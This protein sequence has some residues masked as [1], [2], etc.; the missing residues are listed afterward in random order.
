MNMA[1]VAVNQRAFGLMGVLCVGGIAAFLLLPALVGEMDANA[2]ALVKL[3]DDW[4]AAA[5]ARDIE[6]VASFYAEDAMAYPPN[7]PVAMGR[8]AAKK[9]WAELLADPSLAISWKATNAEVS[10]SGELA[11]TSGTYELSVK[12]P[13]GKPVVEKGKY[14]CVWK[15]DKDGNWK[16]AH[17]MWN[18]DSK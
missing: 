15:K 13:D 1:T 16:A 10:K 4:S 17:D 11:F 9:V 7:E 5:G 8:A 6:R 18:A 14:L 3:D 2:K 12:A